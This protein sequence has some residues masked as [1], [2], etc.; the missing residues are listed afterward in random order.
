M[1]W[2]YD[3]ACPL[4]RG[5]KWPRKTGSIPEG[6]PTPTLA[7]N[8][9]PGELVRVKSHEQILQTINTGSRNRGLWWD[10]ELV[11]YCG[12][13]Y[14]VA[15]RIHNVIDEKSGKM[16]HMKSPSILLDTVICQARYSPCRMFCPRSTYAFWREIWLERTPAPSC[17]EKTLPAASES[18]P[19]CSSDTLEKDGG[20]AGR[21]QLC[22]APTD[23]RLARE[24]R[25]SSRGSLASKVLKP[26]R[27]L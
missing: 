17:S 27:R 2:F 3:L 24:E 16:V 7:L 15:N 10:A 12:K 11:P 5:S 4:W 8:L 19:V 14:R 21:N 25:L 22:L 20:V 1:R 13:T 23:S 18:G 26:W 6:Q 9:Q